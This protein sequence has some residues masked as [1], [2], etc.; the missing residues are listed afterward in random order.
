MALA[1]GS[2]GAG[3][4][5]VILGAVALAAARPGRPIAVQDLVSVAVAALGAAT[6]AWLA[7]SCALGWACLAGRVVGAQWRAGE[8]VLRRC[9]PVVVRRAVAGA[10]GA[11]L[12][13]GLVA[14]GAHAAPAVEGVGVATAST[15]TA[16]EA[17]WD[18][19]PATG[20]DDV[21]GVVLDTGSDGFAGAPSAG[22][23]R[24]TGVA[25]AP[26]A[27]AAPDPAAP[28]LTW[29]VTT[30][31]PGPSEDVEDEAP[32]SGAGDQQ[33]T[34]PAPAPATGPTPGDA[35]SEASLVPEL[36][37]QSTADGRT[38][39]AVSTGAD[40]GADG[41]PAGQTGDARDTLERVVVASGDSL[42]SIAAAHLPADATTADIAAAWP[43]WYEANRTVIGDDPDVLLVGQS[44]EVPME[45]AR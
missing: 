16:S 35:R 37:A 2:L 3:L 27:V 41:Q 24:D 45:T 28:S 33:G 6:A 30:P 42:W 38:A 19:A 5:A 22:K 1:A 39:G 14:T 15:T 26:A 10:V 43:R 40:R 21:V 9:A 31:E 32:R 4:L 17:A 36:A 18:T 11:S 13:L 12:G 7:A 25:P 34:A 23:G 29:Q 44:L 8:A 20:S